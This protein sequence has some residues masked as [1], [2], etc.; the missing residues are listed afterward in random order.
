MIDSKTDRVTERENIKI[1]I[2]EM[3][4]DDEAIKERWDKKR[5]K[6]KRQTQREREKRINRSLHPI[7]PIM[8]I[9]SG[10]AGDSDCMSV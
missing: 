6:E 10:D 1:V 5:E 4:G 7:I 8:L 9:I 3:G 2:K